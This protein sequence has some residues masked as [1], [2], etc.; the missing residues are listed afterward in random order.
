MIEQKAKWPVNTKIRKILLKREPLKADHKSKNVKTRKKEGQINS[1]VITGKMTETTDICRVDP[2][3]SNK[4]WRYLESQ[5]LARLKG[6][7]LTGIPV[8]SRER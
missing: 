4:H 7:T 8:Y 5:G 6:S 2:R 1:K 3:L